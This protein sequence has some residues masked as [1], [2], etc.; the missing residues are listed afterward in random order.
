MKVAANNNR[1]GSNTV[2]LLNVCSY[3]CSGFRQG[4]D[5]M[6]NLVERHVTDFLCVQETWLLDSNMHMLGSIHEK[7]D[8]HGVSGVNDKADIIQG[9][10]YG[11]VAILWR[12]EL[13]SKVSVIVTQHPRLCAIKYKCN[14]NHSLLIICLYMPC[15]N[16]RVTCE[17]DEYLNVLDEVEQLIMANEYNDVIICGDW[18]TDFSRCNAQTSSL[19]NFVDRN[20][21]HICWNHQNAKSEP[22][23]NS[24]SLGH[25]S[26]VDHVISSV[27]IHDNIS[28]CSVVH[29]IDN[30]SSHLPVRIVFNMHHD[31]TV[32]RDDK[33]NAH[34]PH[35]L[36]HKVT[37]NH[38]K[39]YQ[40]NIDDALQYLEFDHDMISCENIL[41]DNV[42]HKELIDKYC[43]K[44]INVCIDAGKQIFPH[45][46]KD[47][48]PVPTWNDEVKELRDRS[49]FWHNVWIQSGKPATGHVADI[50]RDTRR[51]YHDKIK[52]IKADERRIRNKKLADSMSAGG[53]NR[54][55]WS[56]IKK[57]NAFNKGSPVVM[58]GVCNVKDIC[59]IFKS[60]YENIYTSAPTQTNELNEIFN[61]VHSLLS[62][63]ADR[64]ALG[65]NVYDIKKAFRKLNKGKG[66]GQNSS[67]NHFIYASHKFQV[68][69]SIL[70]KCMLSH[71]YT[72]N[73]LLVS[74]LVS[75][76]KDNKASLSN[77]DNYRGIALC[78]AL[79][80]VIDLWILD[81]FST[82]LCSSI[83]Q[84]AF[85]ESHST[86][87]CSVV[88]KET[89]EY[90]K[91]KGSNTYACLLDA[92]KAFD[93]LHY[94][95]LFSILLK[96]KIDP[97]IVRFVMDTYLRQKLYAQWNGHTSDQIL[98]YNGVRQGA[99]LSPVLF[100]LYIDELLCKLEKLPYGCR[101]GTKYFG[102]F[103]YADDLTLVSPSVSGLQH[104]VHECEKFGKE[105]DILFNSS[106]SKA[107]CFG[108]SKNVALINVNGK[109]LPWLPSVEHLGNH[110]EQKLS[111][112]ADV[113]HKRGKFIQS[114][115]K[116]RSMFGSVTSNVLSRLFNSYCCSYYGCQMWDL[117]GCHIK[118]I[119]T[120]WNKAIRKIWNIPWKSHVKLLPYINECLYISE[121]LA[122]RFCKFYHTMLSCPNENVSLI[123]QLAKHSTCTTLGK[124]VAYIMSHYNL[125]YPF[126]TTS[127]INTVKRNMYK[128]L[129][130]NNN[131][132]YH[133]TGSVI[134]ELCETRD[135]ISLMDFIQTE[136]ICLLIDELCVN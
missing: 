21:L 132:E 8:F 111:D 86:V 105:Y 74:M 70:M 34:T 31:V 55:L 90:F 49:L 45:S 118:M 6:H 120:A 15:D 40:R 92:S 136:D 122:L 56:E 75:I 68:I 76:P 89:V 124:N 123:A 127:G 130:C 17:S 39:L 134:R 119:Y 121:Q 71:G 79:C 128:E 64:N 1:S 14:A 37:E 110:M 116:L 44:I 103:C 32:S 58:N 12:N 4:K 125:F 109:N 133:N 73:D 11:G 41:C 101:I 129:N 33:C 7:Y 2:N 51:K 84:Y 3:N 126:E 97:I 72:P 94:G 67:S 16:Y 112:N 69:F 108:S 81:R 96:R 59:N 104:M 22:T 26:H 19:S 10:P 36:W 28:S 5:F 62:D 82:K 135:G 99:V 78:N 24:L 91:N 50:M 54:D 88:F 46:G 30:L 107:I 65:I 63:S 80:K 52:V 13:S 60:K 117:S 53:N 83:H 77:T 38:I 25:T 93:R 61:D 9:R 98:T 95:K 29:D 113:K 27:D 114:V 48:K 35:V 102:S 87:L 131:A 43:N 18:N 85:K 57:I 115:N 100:C 20:G 47:F 42:K 66:D 23:Y 106:K